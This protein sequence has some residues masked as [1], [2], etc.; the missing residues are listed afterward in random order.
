MSPGSKPTPILTRTETNVNLSES[1]LP[2]EVAGKKAYGVQWTGTLTPAES[3][4]Y[5][6][7]VR[8]HGFCRLTVDDKQVAA[9]FGGGR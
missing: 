9:A 8:C 4:D 1:N 6:L 5:Q 7:G 3:G 2:K